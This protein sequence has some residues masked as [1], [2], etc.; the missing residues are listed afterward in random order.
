MIGLVE[1]FLRARL[2]DADPRIPQINAIVDAVAADRRILKVEDVA[3]RFGLHPRTLQRLFNQYVGV[4]P[5]WVIQRYRLHEA[6][7]QVAD[8]AAANWAKL[9]Q[10]LGYFDQAHFIRDFKAMIGSTPAEY[11]RQTHSDSPLS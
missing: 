9:A 1:G 11:A 5:K 10:D 6:A 2:P 7:E 8:G 3:D 4:S